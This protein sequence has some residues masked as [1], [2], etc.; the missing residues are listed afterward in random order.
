M[1]MRRGQSYDLSAPEG[2]AFHCQCHDFGLSGLFGDGGGIGCGAE[3]CFQQLLAVVSNAGGLQHSLFECLPPSDSCCEIRLL[4]LG[5]RHPS[6]SPS[7]SP[8]LSWNNGNAL[9]VVNRGFP[10]LS[11]HFPVV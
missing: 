10:I 8:Y 4:G 5:A 3:N 1:T 9:S 11:T 7:L 2:P 6:S